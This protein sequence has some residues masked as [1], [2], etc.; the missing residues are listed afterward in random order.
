MAFADY[1]PAQANDQLSKRGGPSPWVTALLTALTPGLGH[2]YLGQARRGVTL[3][4]LVIIADTLLMFAMMGVLARFWMFAVSLAL[5]VGLWLYIMGDAILRAHRMRDFPHQR[6]NRWT[7]YAGAFVLAC[8]IF[9][10]P[11]V[12]AVHAK[13][14]GRLLWLNVASPSM[15][16]TLRLGEYFLADATYYR[17]RHPSRGEVAVYVHPKQEQV[18]YIKR[19]VAVEGDRIAIKGGRAIVNGMMVEEPYVDAGDPKARFA[20]EAEIRVPP[21]HVYV[22]GDNRANSVDSRDRIAHGPVPVANLIGRVT[23]IAISR[24]VFRMGRWIGTPSKL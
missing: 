18:H 17:S 4:V 8:L 3:F 20:N 12:Y 22:L 16:P 19:I 2:L 6:Y 21:G 13:S 15:E 11:C 5:L 23:D 1:A 10:G 7:T 24:H 14:S 9:A